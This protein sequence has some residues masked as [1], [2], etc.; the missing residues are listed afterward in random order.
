MEPYGLTVVRYLAS[1]KWFVALQA[2]YAISIA[3]IRASIAAALLRFTTASTRLKHLLWAVIGFSFLS[4]SIAF[5]GV[6]TQVKPLSAMWTVQ[7]DLLILSLEV[8]WFA[9]FIAAKSVVLD[10]ADR[11]S[12]V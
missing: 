4:S 8:H 11:K 9:Y 6:V 10:V 5:V 3:P 7:E 12:V 2:S 1:C